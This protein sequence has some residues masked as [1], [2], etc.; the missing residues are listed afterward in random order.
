MFL[1]ALLWFVTL[2]FL[3]KCVSELVLPS[4][5]LASLFFFGVVIKFSL[6]ELL[7][8]SVACVDS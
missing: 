6:L 7:S 4:E 8:L 1:A 5:L 3:R 2:P